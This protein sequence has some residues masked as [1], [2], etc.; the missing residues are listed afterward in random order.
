MKN[1]KKILEE[2]RTHKVQILLGGGQQALSHRT[3]DVDR[4]SRALKRLRTG[5]YGACIDCGHEIPQ[6]R[7][8]IAPEAERCVSC[9]T[10]FEKK[11]H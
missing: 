8:E 4:I 10:I 3:E 6:K 5:S 2:K 11:C 9:Q 7:L 1:L